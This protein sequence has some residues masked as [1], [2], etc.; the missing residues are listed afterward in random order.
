MECRDSRL[1]LCPIR[2]NAG[3][4]DQSP[5]ERPVESRPRIRLAAG[6]NVAVSDHTVARQAGIGAAQG[7]DHPGECMVL[8]GLV[9]Q[10]VG[11]LEFDAD[12][13]VI[14]RL[15]SFEAG[16]SGMPGAIGEFDV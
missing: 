12:G 5:G 8:G 3:S 6:C 1:G 15:A 9:S 11:A 4:L 13:I 14:A 10:G 2:L 7:G 16:S